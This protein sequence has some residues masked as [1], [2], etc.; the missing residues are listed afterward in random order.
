[1]IVLMWLGLF[2]VPILTGMGFLTVFYRKNKDYG[3]TVAE[4]F[5]LGMVIG[6]GLM[7]VGHLAGLFANLSL[8]RVVITMGVLWIFVTVAALVALVVL[9]ARQRGKLGWLNGHAGEKTFLPLVFIGLLLFQM[10]FVFCMKPVNTPGD[11]T[12]ETVQSFLAEDGIYRVMPLT[13]DVSESG[14]PLRYK[15]LCLPTLYAVLSKGFQVEASLLVCHVVPVVV[16]AGMYFSY[17][18]LSGVLFGRTALKKRYLFL[19]IVALL[20]LFTDGAV[21]S[22]G[23][24]G[25]H[26]GYLGTSIRNLILVPY[27]IAAA[28]EK[29]WWKALLCVL[30]E[31]CIAW[32]LW[33]CGVCL[34]VLAGMYLITMLEQKSPKI[35][36]I[37][38]IFCEK[39]D[40]S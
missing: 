4:G 18:H 1:M 23:Y 29:R 27:T 32:T 15:I 14:M 30:A 38:Q 19:V 9:L 2:F 40:L 10:L 11:I 7:Q 6:I 24:N 21:F 5:V 26:G 22:D 31:V 13:G 25:L 33:G 17:Y 16:L 34:L 37:M 39:E 20:M 12:L 36:G 28:L 3:I 35:R 8:G